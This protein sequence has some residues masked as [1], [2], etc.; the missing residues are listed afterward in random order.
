MAKTAHSAC[1]V[2]VKYSSALGFHGIL[3]FAGVSLAHCAERGVAD[4][5]RVQAVDEYFPPAYTQWFR[6]KFNTH[7][8]LMRSP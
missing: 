4:S 1:F 5:L 3:P 6:Q 2:C 7:M 8:T